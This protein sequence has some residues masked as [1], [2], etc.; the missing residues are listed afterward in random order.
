VSNAITG[1]LILSAIAKHRDSRIEVGV[2]VAGVGN[3]RLTIAL[4]LVPETSRGPKLAAIHHIEA[5]SSL[6]IDGVGEV[7]SSDGTTALIVIRRENLR[8][9]KVEDTSG[10]QETSNIDEV[11]LVLL[12]S[13]H[14]TALPLVATIIIHSK[15]LVD[16]SGGILIARSEDKDNRIHASTLIASIKNNSLILTLE[17]VPDTLR[18]VLVSLTLNLSGSEGR[19]ITLV[20]FIHNQSDR[21]L[22][23]SADGASTCNR[24]EETYCNSKNS[25]FAHPT[26]KKLKKTEKQQE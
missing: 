9:S 12:S 1:T 13:E 2:G 16:V 4:N 24:H 22:A 20:Q 26:N 6:T 15:T 5:S 25:N 10:V 18:A 17:V 21:L 8:S 19:S 14:N 11:I 7:R 3:V 23:C